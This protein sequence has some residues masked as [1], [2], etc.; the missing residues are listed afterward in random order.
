MMIEMTM[1]EEEFERL[2]SDSQLSSGL[3]DP[4]ETALH[5][6]RHP[7]LGHERKSSKCVCFPGVVRRT[8]VSSD[9]PRRVQMK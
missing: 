7:H 1:E 5:G 8:L 3:G 9:C 6:F 2:L 4:D